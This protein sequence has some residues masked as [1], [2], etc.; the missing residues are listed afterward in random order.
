MKV[1]IL[2]KEQIVKIHEA[3][4][5]IL[6]RIGVIVPHDEVLQR[7]KNNGAT[8]DNKTGLVKIPKALVIS[9]LDKPNKRPAITAPPAK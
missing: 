7:F 9:S 6:E 2:N 3:S 4:L 8:V 5:E 1:E